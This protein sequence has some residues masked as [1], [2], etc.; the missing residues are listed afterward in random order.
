M[1]IFISLFGVSTILVVAL[2]VI[3]LNFVLEEKYIHC[4]NLV[5]YNPFTLF[6][7]IATLAW[8]RDQGKG[9]QGCGPSGRPGSTPHA[10]GS[11]KS[12]RE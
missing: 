3:F 8:A 10:P 5:L 6:P 2:L 11:A 12:V 9:L 7:I 4:T 1:V